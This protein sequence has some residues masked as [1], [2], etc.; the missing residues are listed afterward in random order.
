MKTTGKLFLLFLFISSCQNQW[1]EIDIQFVREDG[2]IGFFLSKKGN[3]TA[4]IVIILPGS[5]KNLMDTDE[6]AGLVQEGYDVFSIAYFGKRH[7]PE[8]IAKVPIEYIN[9]CIKWIKKK[10]N[11]ERK[12]FLL[13][14]SKGAE[15]GLIYAS[16]FQNIDGLICYS[17]SNIVLPD[18]VGI[19]QD[20]L[21]VSS[22][23]YE[24]KEIAFADIAR[25]NEKAGEVIYKKY[26]DPVFETSFTSSKG[27]I[28][29]RMIDCPILLLSGKSDLVWPAYKMSEM[30]VKEIRQYGKNKNVISIGYKNAG[31]Q[32][33]WLNKEAP[34]KV[35]TGQSTRLSG[36]KKHKFI[37]GGTRE[38]TK[39]AM[40]E[41]RKEVLKFLEFFE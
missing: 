38:G 28:N 40:I 6:V 7:L 34:T 9:S 39:A 3:E 23:T 17:P 4:P 30:M 25:F 27:L 14:I 29:V 35:T 8:R 1:P 16:K 33:F 12:I 22:W 20:D 5:G 13:G 11:K 36:I 41:S 2:L 37:Y 10:K 15:L 24:G 31:H 19:D 32:F 21:H 26:I 18:H